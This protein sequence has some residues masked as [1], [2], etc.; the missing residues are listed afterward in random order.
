MTIWGF[1]SVI[2]FKHA[3]GDELATYLKIRAAGVDLRVPELKG[4]CNPGIAGDG[5]S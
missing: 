5:H 3:V 2:L 4:R 1:Q